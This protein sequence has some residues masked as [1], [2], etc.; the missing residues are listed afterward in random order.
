MEANNITVAGVDFATM[1]EIIEY[2]ENLTRIDETFDT[3]VDKEVA[4]KEIGYWS[5]LRGIIPGRVL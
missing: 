3:R 5:L 1:M 4:E 2:C